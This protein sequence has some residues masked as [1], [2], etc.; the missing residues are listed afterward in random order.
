ME[1]HALTV[2]PQVAAISGKRYRLPTALLGVRCM[3]NP[4]VCHNRS[5]VTFVTFLKI[6]STKIISLRS[7]RV[8]H[9]Q[10]AR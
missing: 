8:G 9:T 2:Q 7:Q 5:T 6:I 10:P 4:N 1:L 3:K